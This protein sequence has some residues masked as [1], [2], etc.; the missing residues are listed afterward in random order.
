LNAGDGSEGAVYQQHLNC[1]GT[2]GVGSLQRNDPRD[3]F[4][5]RAI[6]RLGKIC[7]L[8]RSMN[9][10]IEKGGEWIEA[11]NYS[12]AWRLAYWELGKY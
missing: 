5:K 9:Y 7:T 8:N 4:H 2:L 10:C 1:G 12:E 11:T 3:V 6:I